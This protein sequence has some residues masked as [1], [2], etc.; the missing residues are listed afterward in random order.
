[1]VLDSSPVA[2]ICSGVHFL[3][4]WNIWNLTTIDFLKKSSSSRFLSIQIYH[5]E[6]PLIKLFSSKA[7][8][9]RLLRSIRADCN[10]FSKY[11]EWYFKWKPFFVLR[12]FNAKYCE[13]LFRNYYLI[14]ALFIWVNGEKTHEGQLLLMS[15]CILVYSRTIFF[16]SC[17]MCIKGCFK[18][19]KTD[20]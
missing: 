18:N 4:R 3:F 19:N 20:V 10:I 15:W 9:C 7:L 16:V 17:N 2:A 6:K 5:M 14:S 1:M 11:Q 13:A 12:I 8:R